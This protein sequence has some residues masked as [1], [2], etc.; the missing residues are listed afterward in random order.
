MREKPKA[1]SSIAGRLNLYFGGRML[2][3]FLAL[4]LVIL[5]GLVF[6]FFTGWKNRRPA[7]AV[8]Q[9]DILLWNQNICI[10]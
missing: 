7:A 2:G 5:L 4:D 10:T 6:T 9:R 8:L 1:A 3:A